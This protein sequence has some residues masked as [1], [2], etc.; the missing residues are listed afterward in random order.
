LNGCE[1][2]YGEKKNSW[3]DG[4]CLNKFRIE[5]GYLNRSLVFV[6]TGIVG[7]YDMYSDTVSLLTKRLHDDNDLPDRFVRCTV[8]TFHGADFVV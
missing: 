8:I 2:S 4:R 7:R 5:F 1:A 6:K 3:L